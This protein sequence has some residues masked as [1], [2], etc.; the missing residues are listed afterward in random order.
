MAPDR[1]FDIAN[2]AC[3]SPNDAI[4]AFSFRYETMHLCDFLAEQVTKTVINGHNI[5]KVGL[6]SVWVDKF[7]NS[8]DPVIY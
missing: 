4:L 6:Y 2:C 1:H 7:E 8:Q 5:A 3:F